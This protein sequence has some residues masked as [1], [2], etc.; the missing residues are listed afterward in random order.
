MKK[1]LLS[2]L[3]IITNGIYFNS[4]ICSK[5]NVEDEKDN[6][7]R[8]AQYQNN[9]VQEYAEEDNDFFAQDQ[10]DNTSMAERYQDDDIEYDD[11]EVENKLEH[12]KE[13]LNSKKKQVKELKNLK[14][15]LT[16]QLGQV[17]KKI[18]EIQVEISELSK[19]SELKK[20]KKINKRLQEYADEDE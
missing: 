11:M 3:F 20:T 16:K 5:I 13:L 18:K 4:A 7:S 1:Y 8:A 14:T 12:K 19:K 9:A 10:K 2:T 6:S 15:K 17:N